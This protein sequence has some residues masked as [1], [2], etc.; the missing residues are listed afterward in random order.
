MQAY[1]PQHLVNNYFRLPITISH[2]DGC[3]LYDDKGR[4][5]L[6]FV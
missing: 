5:Y 6:D 1:T 4:K 3:F 2:G